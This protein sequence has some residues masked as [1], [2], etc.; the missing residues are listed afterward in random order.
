MVNIITFLIVKIHATSSCLYSFWTQHNKSIWS[1]LVCKKDNIIMRCVLI[2]LASMWK[3]CPNRAGKKS[4]Y[5]CYLAAF[6]DLNDMFQPIS[7]CVNRDATP[8]L[9]SSTLQPCWRCVLHC[10]PCAA[11]Q[12]PSLCSLAL[13]IRSWNQ[14]GQTLK[15]KV[16]QIVATCS[17]Q[18]LFFFISF[19]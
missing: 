5:N 1:F 10:A 11:D 9:I 14:K 18:L 4:N 12:Q 3:D 19:I 17:E 8:C 15:T 7:S 6:Q 16:I 2:H 13:K